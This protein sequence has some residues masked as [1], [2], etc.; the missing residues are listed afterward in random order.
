MANIVITGASSGLGAA[1]AREYAEPGATIGLLA[2][3]ARK[4]EAV[5]KDAVA[6][7][8]VCVHAQADIT[9]AAAIGDSI[10]AFDAAHPVDIAI[11][12]AG[13]FDGRAD[14][15]GIEDLD[16]SLR[17]IETNL[18][19]TLKTLH[20]V[21]PGMRARGRGHIVIVASLAGLTPLAGALGYSA[22]KSALVAYGLGLKQTLRK[23]GI[24]VS[25]VCPGFI[26]TAIAKKHQG[27]QPLRMSAQK[28][29]AKIR[30]GVAS[31][32]AIVAFPLVL[33]LIARPSIMVPD[34]VRRI[35]GGFF[36]CSA[37]K[38]ARP[39]IAPVPAKLPAAAE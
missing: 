26:E 24:K 22:S 6:R 21:L 39:A 11:L 9:D 17:V 7:G 30:R 20:A 29:A 3:D 37:A 34:I 13:M 4:L 31:N 8:A 19:G 35:A 16:T 33:H 38:D 36:A 1:L 5:A 25:V 15:E 10:A 12:N 28:A 14:G 23:E 18:Q 27:W 2:R 32:R